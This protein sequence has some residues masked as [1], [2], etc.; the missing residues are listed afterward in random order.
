MPP[1]SPYPSIVDAFKRLT[2]DGVNMSDL[3]AY[4]KV[5]KL[6]QKRDT[7]KHSY[8]GPIR[9]TMFKLVIATKGLPAST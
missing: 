2:I 4:F 9:D 8:W 7:K 1:R 3:N 5:D 6:G